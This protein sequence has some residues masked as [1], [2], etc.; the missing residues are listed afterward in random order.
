M[1]GTRGKK[2]E[3]DKTIKE[4]EGKNNLLDKFTN[5]LKKL[6]CGPRNSFVK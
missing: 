5:P 3:K 1:K 4:L 6:K 2:D